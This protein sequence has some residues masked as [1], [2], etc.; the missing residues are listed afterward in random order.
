M[1]TM[2][3]ALYDALRAAGAPDDKAQAAAK[4]LA[5]HDRRFGS[6]EKELAGIH[7]EIKAVRAEVKAVEGQVTMVK[8]MSGATFAGILAPILRTFV[9]A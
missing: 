8:W 5:E 6:I 4:A 3:V 2:I 7:A 9:A 1:T